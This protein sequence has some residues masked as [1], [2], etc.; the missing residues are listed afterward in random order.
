MFSRKP[1]KVSQKIE[2]EHTLKVKL[3]EGSTARSK[4]LIAKQ[5]QAAASAVGRLRC[6]HN[7]TV[8]TDTPPPPPPPQVNK[9]FPGSS[10]EFVEF[11]DPLSALSGLLI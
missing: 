5:K 7:I 1:E 8:F 4:K 11:E 10:I 6:Y 3:P 9:I 2:G